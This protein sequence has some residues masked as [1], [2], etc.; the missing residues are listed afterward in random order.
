MR[1]SAYKNPFDKETELCAHFMKEA[2]SYG[3]LSYPE[4][5]EFDMLLVATE[6]VQGHF[7]IGDQIGI[8]AK[9]VPNI[10][11][12][13]QSLPR[14]ADRSG[15][16][17]YGVLVPHAT[18]EFKELAKHLKIKVFEAACGIYRHRGLTEWEQ[19]PVKGFLDPPKL[20]YP[21]QHRKPS[22]V[23]DVHVKME[24]GAAGPKQLTPWKIKAVKLA[25]HGV[26]KGYLTSHDFAVFD[27]KMVR[28]VRYRW[29]VAGEFVVEDGKRRR[30]Y[31][32]NEKM[33]PPH[34]KFPEV[35]AALQA[36]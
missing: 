36:L 23:P 12:L 4:T 20:W 19:G 28:W 21:H 7:N 9:L 10:D 18:A 22:W 29:I 16:N 27:V 15:P 6:V 26:T 32:L 8:Q 11:V 2:E 13:Y 33:S 17:Y 35:A 34:L 30:K 24:A 5:D 14:R 31:Y 3:W 25:L 1:R